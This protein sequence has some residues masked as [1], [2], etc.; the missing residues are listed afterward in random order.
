MDHISKEIL[1]S[2]AKSER[3]PNAYLFFGANSGS[4]LDE[5]L[6]LAKVLDCTEKS[7]CGAC[8]NCLKISKF[9]HPDLMLISGEGKAIGI[10]EVRQAATY[11]RYGP[12]LAKWKVV[13]VRDAD[14][15]T[16][17]ASNSFLKT[18]E[19]PVS[20]VLYILTTT[21]EQRILKTISSRCQK[22]YFP[23]EKGRSE[24]T[25]ISLVE[26]FILLDKT[27][28]PELIQYADELSRHPD[29]EGVLN[30]I[31]GSYREKLKPSSARQFLG[32]R[33]IFRGIRAI[34]R[35][36]N[37]KLAMESMLLSMKGGA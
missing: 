6:S 32:I 27:E 8:D 20:N 4:L 15:L 7:G 17:D 11:T 33:N 12:T 9:C 25:D 31:I 34:E 26:R 10:D 13:I 1:L 14:K 2:A 18:L 30:S 22:I 24:T 19:E 36:G 29:L 23:E 5:A 37:K 3:V 21:R 35:H 16:E 28:I